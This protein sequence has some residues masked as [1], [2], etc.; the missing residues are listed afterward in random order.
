MITLEI[1]CADIHSV[2]AAVEG[3]ANRIELCS[4]LEVGGLTPS[5]GLLAEARKLTAGKVRLHVLIRPRPGDYIY[6][7]EEIEVMKIDIDCCGQLGCDGVVIGAL[8]PDGT[9]NAHVTREL[10]DAASPYNMSVTF[11]RAFD[12]CRD[13]FEALDTLVEIGGVDRVLTSGLAASA[14]EGMEMLASL[15]NKGQGSISIMP[16]AGVT[17]ANAAMI[18]GATGAGEIHA[19]AKSRVGSEMKFRRG[20]VSMGTPGADEYSRFTTSASEVAAIVNT[21]SQIQ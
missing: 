2:I 17:S 11:H 1:C 10:L 6:T 7:A 21:L 16:G 9:V 18:I 5:P 12:L 19:S 20:D 3:G 4:A 14:P 15:V 8:N 13:P